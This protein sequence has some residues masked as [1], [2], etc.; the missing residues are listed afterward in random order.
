MSASTT[1]SARRPTSES[2]PDDWWTDTLHAYGYQPTHGHH[3]PRTSDAYAERAWLQLI[4]PTAFLAARRLC[5]E[6]HDYGT[7]VAWPVDQFARSLGVGI[8]AF[9][10]AI[11]RLERARLVHVDGPCL[12]V[13]TTWPD[14]TPRQIG[15]L[16][17]PLPKGQ[18]R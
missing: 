11:H 1:A 14:L 10:N 6:L 5:I 8:P 3:D 2:I 9:R 4:G 7:E 12:A 15:R 16:A 18:F 13:H 17:R